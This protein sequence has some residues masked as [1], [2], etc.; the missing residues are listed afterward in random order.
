LQFISDIALLS[1]W[2]DVPL[3]D[4]A[5]VDCEAEIPESSKMTDKA[6]ANLFA[7]NSMRMPIP[8]S[9]NKLLNKAFNAPPRIWGLRCPFLF[10]NVLRW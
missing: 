10:R 3:D 4:P 1:S 6:K 7:F 9:L 5:A 2:I 8:I